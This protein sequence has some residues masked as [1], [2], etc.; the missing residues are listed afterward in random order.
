MIEQDS[1]FL[2]IIQKRLHDNNAE[3]T[4]EEIKKLEEELSTQLQILEFKMTCLKN[5][6]A[7]LT[8]IINQESLYDFEYSSWAGGQG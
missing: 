3:I 2:K 6:Q 1:L 7:L 4:I 8:R 5:R